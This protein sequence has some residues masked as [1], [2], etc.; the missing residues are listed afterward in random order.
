MAPHGS[1]EIQDKLRQLK[2]D[3]TSAKTKQLLNKSLNTLLLSVNSLRK[4]CLHPYVQ[5]KIKNCFKPI[6]VRKSLQH[7]FQRGSKSACIAC[8][9]IG[10][11][12]ILT[13]N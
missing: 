5:T 11:K 12:D 10:H 13:H 4:S 7:V 3:A 8:I 2:Q 6:L 1:N 9:V